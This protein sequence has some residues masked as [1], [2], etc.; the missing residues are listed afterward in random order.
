M[1][2]LR[3][4]GVKKLVSIVIT[5]V[6]VVYL[7]F[8]AG[9]APDTPLIAYTLGVALLM[10][11]L[12]ITEVVP[13]AV[14]SLIPVAL[15]PL[16]GIMDGRAVA[17][18]YF[19]DVIFLF[20]GGFLVSLAMEKWDLH[21]R[22]AYNILCFTGT[23]P[24]RIL[25]G[26]MLASFFLSMWISNTATAMMML[27]IA[28][29]IIR[30]LN[31]LMNNK[32]SARFSVGILLG[33]AYSASV[34]GMATLVGT[35]PNLSFMRIFHIYFPD[36][37]EITFYKWML[38]ALPVAV[39]MFLFVWAFLYML[40]RPKKTEWRDVDKNTFHDQLKEMGGRTY[41]Q[42]IVFVVFV[43]L[44]VLWISRADLDFG[45]VRIPGWS[46][47]LPSAKFVNDGTVAIF[48]ALILFFIPSRSVK[49]DAI[50][51][52]ETASK[53]PWNIL[54]LFGGGFALATGFKESGL[55]LWFGGHLSGVASLHPFLVVF[56]ICLVITA[57]TELTSNTATTEMVLPIL[58]G[59]AI[60][61][62]I[63]PL[64]LMIPATMSA[65]MAFML[66]VATPPNA[67]IFGT[68]MVSV[69][70]MAVTGLLI[71]IVG[72][73]ICALVMYFWGASF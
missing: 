43:L 37:A 5:P 35:P 49:G 13:L 18:T 12:W 24:A 59:I 21:K 72:A 54:L 8:F 30:Q 7:M 42:N 11:V 60:T 52:W 56:I 39:L 53:L 65:S 63:N 29:A 55:S 38:F 68:G 17:A 48:M 6:M 14:T 73:I 61:T 9:V 1:G 23:S 67:I 64:M 20:M 41:E 22:I 70:Q 50:L 66:P 15:F 28:M 71:N 46:N 57:L 51:E 27:P 62:G 33:I 26:F 2:F 16:F 45:F 36:A 34:G 10:A 25:L 44:A 32:S 19:N 58:A 47:L 4:F 69:R 31:E 3:H 40:F